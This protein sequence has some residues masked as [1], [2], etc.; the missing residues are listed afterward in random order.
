MHRFAAITLLAGIASARGLTL[1]QAVAVARTNHPALAALRCRIEAA[2]GRAEQ[3]RL[4]PNPELELFSED[5]PPNRGGFAS[6]KNMVGISQTIPVPGKKSLDTRIGQ[7]QITA[8]RL[9]YA[10]RER[11]V[12]QAVQSAF[13][14]ALAAQ[15]KVAVGEE[16][17]A[18]SRSLLQVAS[19]RI[20]AGSA[21]EPERLRAEIELD[22][23]T[24]ELATLQQQLTE[25]KLALAEAMGQSHNTIATLQGELRTQVP[26]PTPAPTD[27]KLLAQHPAIR[28]TAAAREQAE[29]ELR[30]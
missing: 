15:K 8:A 12:V 19:Q 6:A 4:W 30:R 7:Q 13:Y 20:A 3:A 18:L 16:L 28:A 25:A 21:G 17:V 24:I 1:E 27:T 23:A 11:Q 22:R 2:A 14:R 9:E 29:L 10:L 5:F 26:T